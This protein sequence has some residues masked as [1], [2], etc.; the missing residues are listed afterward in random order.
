MVASYSLQ[1]DSHQSIKIPT[2]EPHSR[3]HAYTFNSPLNG[4]GLWSWSVRSASGIGY[5]TIEYINFWLFIYKKLENILM[6]AI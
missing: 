1:I 6:L 5:E 4:S 2:T 3:W